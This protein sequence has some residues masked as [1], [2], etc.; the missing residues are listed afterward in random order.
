MMPPNSAALATTAVVIG[1]ILTSLALIESVI[2]DERVKSKG[3]LPPNEI[4]ASA[5]SGFGQPPGKSQRKVLLPSADGVISMRIGP[6]CKTILMSHYR[7][8]ASSKRG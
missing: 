6:L 8:A 1:L 5:L 2:A 3:T 4:N 7:G